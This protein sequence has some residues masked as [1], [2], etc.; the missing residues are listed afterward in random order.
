MEIKGA[1]Y[2][3]KYSNK[4]VI[5]ANCLLWKIENLVNRPLLPFP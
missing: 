2:F 3:T 5:N 1:A 4:L